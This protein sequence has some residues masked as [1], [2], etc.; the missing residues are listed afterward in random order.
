MWIGVATV[1]KSMEV[2][3]KSKNIELP[4]NLAILLL[5]IYSPK[6]KQSIQKDTYTS[7]FIA[8]LF[9]MLPNMEAT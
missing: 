8:A 2:S 4:Y 3:Q 9:I 1:E 7:M 5:G 6:P